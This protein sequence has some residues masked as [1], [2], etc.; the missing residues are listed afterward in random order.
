VRKLGL[1]KNVVFAG[2]QRDVSPWLT[3]ARVFVLTSDWEGLSLA[4]LEAMSRGLPAVVSRVGDLGEAVEDGVNGYL[5]AGRAPEGFANRI[6]ELL[7]D[8][9][10]LGRFGVA[11]REA[12]RRFEISA[13]IGRWDEILGGFD[14]AT[15]D[16]PSGQ[17]AEGAMLGAGGR[18]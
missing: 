6:V 3:G 8:Q 15:A 11:A 9:E 7:S 17:P 13:A 14:N 5:V 2:Q 10:R 1:E 4:L 18:R 12:A 16:S